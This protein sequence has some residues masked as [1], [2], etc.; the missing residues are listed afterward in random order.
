MFLTSIKDP[1]LMA[2]KA[3]ITSQPK[4]LANFDA[5]TNVFVTAAA[6]GF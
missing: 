2:T 6:F 5:F 3:T 1:V 4:L